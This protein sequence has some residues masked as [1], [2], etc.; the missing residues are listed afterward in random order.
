VSRTW[1]DTAIELPAGASVEIDIGDSGALR[2]ELEV[3]NDDG[4]L[5]R[6]ADALRRVVVEIDQQRERNAELAPE[7]TALVTVVVLDRGP[8]VE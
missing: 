5:V 8:R 6:L 1:F 7:M 3:H 4:T 2:V